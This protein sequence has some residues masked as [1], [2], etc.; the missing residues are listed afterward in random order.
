[1][2]GYMLKGSEYIT[3]KYVTLIQDY[4]ELKVIKKQQTQKEFLLSSILSQNSAK[5]SFCK[6]VLFSSA[7]KRTTLI[8]IT[9]LTKQ[10]LFTMHVLLT[11]QQLTPNPRRPHSLLC[12]FVQFLFH[13]LPLFVKIAYKPLGLTASLWFSFF[14]L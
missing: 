1:M 4:F 2:T 3:P 12:Q 13:T 10:L 6:G 11:L 5:I 9:N 8:C 14:F 7:R